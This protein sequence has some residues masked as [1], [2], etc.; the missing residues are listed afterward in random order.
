MDEVVSIVIDIIEDILE[1]VLASEHEDNTTEDGYS[2]RFVK[3][4]ADITLDLVEEV[5]EQLYLETCLTIG[6]SDEEE[7]DILDHHSN[8]I[9]EDRFE[10]IFLENWPNKN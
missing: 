1:D 6:D 5:F 9:I 8:Q 4:P 10:D 2:K 3:I 7:E